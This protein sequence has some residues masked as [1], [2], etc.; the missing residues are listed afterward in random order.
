M[1]RP[2]Y[3]V[4]RD[5]VGT[6]LLAE[7]TFDFKIENKAHLLVIVA[8]SAGLETQRVRGTDTTYLK[9]V[10]FD[11]KRGG[12]KV[13]L[14]VNLPNGHKI[15]LLLANDEPTQPSEFKGKFDLTLE[16]LENALDFQSGIIQRLMYLVKRTPKLSDLDDANTSGPTF[17]PNMAA[18][19][20]ALL[21]VNGDGTALTYGP[22]F[23]GIENLATTASQVEADRIAAEAAATDAAASAASIDP[24][25]IDN[26]E[27]ADIAIDGRLDALE[28]ST[29]TTD[30]LV[31]MAISNWR[32]GT[33]TD[34]NWT[35]V[36]Y[37]NGKFV[38]ISDDGTS[39]K[40]ATST[41]GRVW[42]NQSNMAINSRAFQAITYGNNLFVAVTNEGT[43]NRVLTSPDGITWTART[44]AADLAWKSITY[45]NGLFVAVATDGT[46]NRVMT[47]PDGITWTSRTSAADSPWQSVTYGNNLFVAVAGSGSAGDVMTSPDGITW[48]TRAPA[49][50]NSWG[51]V[52]Y[53]SGL[54]VAVSYSGAG[55]RVMTSPDGI[56][57][58]ARTP[59]VA[60]EWQ[61]VTFG[62]GTFVAV[63]R[64]GTGNRVMTSPDGI[65]WRSR[66][67][68]ADNF[69]NA[70]TYGDG[71]FVALGA[72]GTGNRS[73]TSLN[74]GLA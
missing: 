63:A 57:W 32:T 37:G 40:V 53:G 42:V 20:N 14:K 18:H 44:S 34:K 55:E 7:Y 28:S 1:A 25:R 47:S 19:P 6:G 33:P 2:A 39:A 16:R 9:K 41:D 45:G 59:A 61:R 69:W 38:A 70:L 27:A 17:P 60:N 66:A 68:A 21:A 26:L 30:S 64:T 15:I 5:H 46:G 52:T 51:S 23:E 67:S 36:A 8:D 48:T 4:R 29:A 10:T 12:G 22:T 73:M 11:S 31:L 54:F 50:T 65:T 56:T 43:G 13:E 58:T 74:I 24:T 49:N 71:L 35:G 3:V 72:S 62:S